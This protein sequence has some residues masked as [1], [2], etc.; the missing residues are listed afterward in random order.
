VAELIALSMVTSVKR[1]ESE[2]SYR[3]AHPFKTHNLSI[4]FFYFDEATAVKSPL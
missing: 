4:I 3:A 1:I 2:M